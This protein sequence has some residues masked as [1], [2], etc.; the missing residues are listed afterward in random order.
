MQ[1]L[2]AARK[3]VLWAT[4]AARPEGTKKWGADVAVPLSRMAE[5]IGEMVMTEDTC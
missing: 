1:S 3:Q 4:L 2:W 5:L